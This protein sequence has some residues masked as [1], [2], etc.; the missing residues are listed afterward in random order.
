MIR[1]GLVGLGEIGQ[2]HLR[3]LRQ[4]PEVE[5]VALCDVDGALLADSAG[6]ERTFE[7][8]EEM[9]GS[10]SLDLVDVCLP[11]S[12]HADVAIAGFEAGAHVLL[13]K[14]MAVSVAECDRINEAAQAFG[15]TVGVSHNQLFYGPH[16]EMERMLSEG[17]LGRLRAIRARLAVGGKYAGW[18]AD[19]EH[20]GGGLAIDAGAH[21]F[22][23]I[24]SLGGPVVSI[25]ATMDEAGVEDAYG[26]V[27]ELAGGA[28]ATIDACYHAPKGVFDD[29]VEIVGSDGLAEAIGVEAL[30]EGFASG[31]PLR[32]WANGRWE[33]RQYPDDW[34]DTV[35][36]SVQAFCTALEGDAPPPVD[37]LAGRRLVELIEGAYLSARTGERVEVTPAA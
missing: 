13:E 36:A 35:T 19:P 31:P 23:L 7:K 12:L 21:R 18:R 1:A 8:L 27:F 20:A 24:E 22:Y 28:I 34:A 4:A 33:E 17:E 10:S 11:H 37:G 26:V 29:R 6:G 15:R 2:V 3:A 9:L 25:A 14:P 16:I 30:F 32:V 5:L